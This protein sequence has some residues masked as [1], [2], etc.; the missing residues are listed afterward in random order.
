MSQALFSHVV[1]VGL[2]LIGSSLARDIH[3]LGLVQHLSG[4]DPDEQNRSLLLRSGMLDAAYASVD[5]LRSATP[6]MDADLL[7]IATSPSSWPEMVQ[8][9]PPL[10]HA[11]SLIMDVGSVKAY[12]AELFTS[13]FVGHGTFIPCHPIAGNAGSGASAGAQG[14]FDNRRIILCPA[15]GTAE[16]PLRIADAFWQ[17]LGGIPEMMPAEVHDRIYALVSHLPQMVAYAA[18]HTLAPHIQHPLSDVLQPFLRLA[19]SPAALWTDIAMT[20]TAMLTEAMEVY[21]H[22]IAHMRGELLAGMDHISEPKSDASI[23]A[24][25]LPRLIASSLVSTVS[26][27]E[28]KHRLK[29]APYAGTGFADV[30][31]PAAQPPEDD[32]ALISDYFTDVAALLEQFEAE[33]RTL[34]L[35]VRD[36]QADTMLRYMQEAQAKHRK[37][38]N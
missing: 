21:L 36:R 6:V 1:I 20:N 31:S 13:A 23:A 14:L 32:M 3:A 22:L 26:L 16:T 10:T 2:G 4:V 29:M 30:A 9:L 17:A 25:L 7:L 34:F 18:M 37:L 11:S 28:R 33:F 35:A 8:C 5:E 19:G 24:Q 38:V 27:S 12:A 15:E